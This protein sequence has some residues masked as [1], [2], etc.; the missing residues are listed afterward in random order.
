MGAEQA[1][2]EGKLSESYSKSI[3]TL[4]VCSSLIEVDSC[5]KREEWRLQLNCT[6]ERMT[7][8]GSDGWVT[9]EATPCQRASFYI[10]HFSNVLC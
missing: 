9:Q 10:L 6:L 3:F 7:I 5:V 4:A 2:P 8:Q 1:G